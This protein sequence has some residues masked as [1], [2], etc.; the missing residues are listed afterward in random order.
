MCVCVF[1]PL[2]VTGELSAGQGAGLHLEEGIW[3]GARDELTEE[4]VMWMKHAEDGEDSVSP[5]SIAVKTMQTTLRDTQ[6]DIYHLPHYIIIN[7]DG[8]QFK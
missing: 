3:G 8:Q 2:L 7:K 6:D 1:L 5:D 4:D